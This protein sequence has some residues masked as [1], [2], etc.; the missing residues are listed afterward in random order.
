MSEELKRKLQ[1]ARK[2]LGMSQSQFAAHLEMPLKTLQ[3]WERD[4]STPRGF[5]LSALNQALD[6]ILG[7][8]HPR[9]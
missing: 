1:E 8:N 4:Q 9:E 6:S 5:A 7:E 2:K 3:G